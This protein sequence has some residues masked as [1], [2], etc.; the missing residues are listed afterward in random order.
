MK[1]SI[2]EK[3]KFDSVF[4]YVLERLPL[5]IRFALKSFYESSDFTAV[6]EIRI[7]KNSSLFL[8]ADSKA[9]K[10]TI[11][12]S[13]NDI[14]DIFEYICKGSYYAYADTI[15]DGFVPLECGVRAGICGNAILENGRIIGINEVSS[16]NIRIPQKIPNA[17]SYIYSI[18]KSNSFSSSI[19]IYSLPGVGKTSILRDLILKL[20]YDESMPRFSVIDSRNE[21]I[22]P[23]MKNLTCDVFSSYP[24]GVGIELATRSMTPEIIICDEI[25]NENDACAIMKASHSGVF[26]I[27][28]THASSLHELTNKEILKGLIKSKT[29]DYYVGVS[30]NKGD[31]R[32]RFTLN[33]SENINVI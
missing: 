24:K 12:I 1:L 4:L 14:E 9:V 25:S 11:Y 17:S 33:S 7:K 5:K 3:R 10:T 23:Y 19:L 20:N 26:L 13:E 30:R 28:T 18:L 29:F 31:T 16:I 8:I 6:N 27:A 32:Y 2:I 22:T 21:I 15:K